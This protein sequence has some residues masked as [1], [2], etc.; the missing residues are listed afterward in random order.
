MT[1]FK[2]HCLELFEEVSKTGEEIRITKRG[3]PLVTVSKTEPA[4]TRPYLPGAFKH[5]V[6][7]TGSI[8]VDSKDLGIEWEAN[9][10]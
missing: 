7:E 4:C 3:K 9:E 8:L 2:A 6:H 5:M 10:S 1:D